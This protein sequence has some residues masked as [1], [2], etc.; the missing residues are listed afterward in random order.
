MMDFEEPT[1]VPD[2]DT[3]EEVVGV[4]VG[5]AKDGMTKTCLTHEIGFAATVARAGNLSE[6]SKREG[7]VSRSSFMRLSCIEAE[8]S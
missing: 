3:V 4:K 8:I 2:P 5:L 1:S 6:A 7:H